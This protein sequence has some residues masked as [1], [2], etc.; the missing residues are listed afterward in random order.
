[1]AHSIYMDS[2]PKVLV[3]DDDPD[4]A[5]TLKAFLGVKGF[6]VTSASDGE[7]GLAAAS[8][9]DFDAAVLDLGLPGKAGSHYL[10]ELCDRVPVVFVLTGIVDETLFAD[11]RLIGA[12]DCL[13]KPI[14]CEVLADRLEK[15]LAAANRA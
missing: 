15:G 3:V 8:A 12:A 7:K 5:F 1:M 13:I 4:L 6:D 2:R 11:L 10:A 9:G 14:D